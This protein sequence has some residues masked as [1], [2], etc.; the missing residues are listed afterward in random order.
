MNRRK[1]NDG[2]TLSAHHFHKAWLLKAK[3]AP[4]FEVDLGMEVKPEWMS[5][6]YVD[7][8]CKDGEPVL[9]FPVVRV[10]DKCGGFPQGWAFARADNGDV[11]IWHCTEGKAHVTIHESLVI[12]PAEF[13]KAVDVILDSEANGETLV[14]G[15]YTEFSVMMEGAQKR[16]QVLD[17][18][19]MEKLYENWFARQLPEDEKSRYSRNDGLLGVRLT[20]LLNAVRLIGFCGDVNHPS[21]HIVRVSPPVQDC[22]NQP[23]TWVMARSHHLILDRSHARQ[24][25]AGRRDFTEGVTSRAAHQ[26]RKHWRTLVSPRF[27]KKRGQRILV[28]QAWI[29]PVEWIGSD[30][31]TYRVLQ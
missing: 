1:L 3:L 2:L 4:L 9:P 6:E 11:G 24:I 21:H 16:P 25:Q 20:L 22:R 13:K 14:G 19:E 30:R 31:K 8:A 15:F 23:R 29:G 17:N 27:T 5:K 7:L 26:R 18:Q 10:I 12:R 28:K